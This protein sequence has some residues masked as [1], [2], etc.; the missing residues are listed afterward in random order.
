MPITD[1]RLY[2]VGQVAVVDGVRHELVQHSA[3]GFEWGYAGSGPA[4]LALNILLAATGNQAFAESHYMSYKAQVIARIPF[5]GGVI[6][7]RDIEAWAL[8]HGWRP[9]HD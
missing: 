3:T 5:E 4:D 2:R 7:G 8:A 1:V 9:K 6:A